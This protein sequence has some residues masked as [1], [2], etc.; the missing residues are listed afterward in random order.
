[1]LREAPG[2]AW[3]ER[4][5]SIHPVPVMRGA[6]PLRRERRARRGSA[7]HNDALRTDAR[8][9][10]LHRAAG[11]AACE[12]DMTS[13]IAFEH[14]RIR[15]MKTVAIAYLKYRD[16]RLDRV[17]ER[18]GRRGL[19]AC[20]AARQGSARAAW[21]RP[22]PRYPQPAA[23]RGSLRP[24]CRLRRHDAC[25]LRPARQ[26]TAPE[27][28]Q[29]PPDVAITDRSEVV[30]DELPDAWSARCEPPGQD[31]A[32]ERA[33]RGSAACALAVVPVES[34]S[35]PIPRSC[36]SPAPMAGIWSGVLRWR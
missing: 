7:L 31:Y 36:A 30:S 32:D 20:D 11:V 10:D 34:S 35:T 27:R 12:F 21:A 16:K 19:A 3:R 2:R 22:A 28:H 13:Q 14:T 24:D 18:L 23:R 29:V 26:P 6:I 9:P 8:R 4:P 25:A 33:S 1:M 17:E 15:M 5:S